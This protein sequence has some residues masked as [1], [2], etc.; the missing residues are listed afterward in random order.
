MGCAHWV[1]VSSQNSLQRE[2]QTFVLVGTHSCFSSSA[3]ALLNRA[4]CL[5]PSQ[6]TLSSGL[7][8]DSE[9]PGATAM[10]STSRELVLFRLVLDM[11]SKHSWGISNVQCM[12][13]NE[14]IKRKR[15]TWNSASTVEPQT[16]WWTGALTHETLHPQLRLKQCGGQGHWPLHSWKS[17]YNF[18]LPKT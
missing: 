12:V 2:L 18:G 5:C 13:L 4:G 14:R 17:A 8:V 3:V 7:H 16:M 10:E 11:L 1:F 15:D 9:L 6:G